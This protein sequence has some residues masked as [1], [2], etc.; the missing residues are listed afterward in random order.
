[1][2]DRKSDLAEGTGRE[3]GGGGDRRKLGAEEI[4]LEM[5]DRPDVVV[6]RVLLRPCSLF[7]LSADV[8][9][10]KRGVQHV[11]ETDSRSSRAAVLARL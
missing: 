3:P 4:G 6:Q 11:A 1:M 7:S 5:W 10:Q 2:T 8:S 9:C